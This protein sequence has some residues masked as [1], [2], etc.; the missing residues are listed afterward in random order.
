MSK[1]K[2]K[3]NDFTDADKSV[4]QL[5]RSKEQFRATQIDHNFEASDGDQEAAG[6]A[7][8][9]LCFGA[10]GELFVKTAE[11]IEAYQPIADS[12]RAKV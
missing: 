3:D 10:N 6:D 8:D 11:E 4:Y 12:E 7:G 5:Y 1:A 2:P 9:F